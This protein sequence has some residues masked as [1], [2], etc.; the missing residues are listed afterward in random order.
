[1]RESIRTN[2]F[3]S[4]TLTCSFMGCHR[5]SKAY[6]WRQLSTA[7]HLTVQMLLSLDAPATNDLEFT[8]AILFPLLSA[9][10][11]LRL[12]V[13]EKPRFASPSLLLDKNWVPGHE[14]MTRRLIRFKEHPPS[15]IHL[16][17]HPPPTPI[18]HVGRL[19]I[20]PPRTYSYLQAS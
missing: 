16:T 19:F 2:S 6:C 9:L 20:S 12:P 13:L 7:L 18:F 11:C 4:D 14:V 15:I 8:I 17:A 3:L 5:V 10:T 1:M